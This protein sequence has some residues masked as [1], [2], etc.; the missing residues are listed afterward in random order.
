MRHRIPSFRPVVLWV[1]LT[2]AMLFAA[3]DTEVKLSG[4]VTDASG[5]GLAGVVL[6]LK[7][8]GLSATSDASGNWSISQTT[9]SSEA[10]F[11]KPVTGS[12]IA[13]A[14]T[15][16]I[17]AGTPSNEAISLQNGSVQVSLVQSGLVRVQ[18]YSLAG[19][20]LRTVLQ[21]H[22][23]AGSYTVA[24]GDIPTGMWIVRVQVG[25]KSKNFQLVNAGNGQST[26]RALH[27]ET[28]TRMLAK[29][30]DAS[31]TLLVS[32][33]GFQAGRIG[34][35][36][37]TTGALSDIVIAKVL[38]TLTPDT[39]GT[40]LNVNPIYVLPGTV[41]QVNYFYDASLWQ[42]AWLHVGADSLV[43]AGASYSL[44]LKSASDAVNLVLVRLQTIAFATLADK[45]Y[46]DEDF[47]LN[48]TSTAGLAVSY[49]SKTKNVCTIDDDIV[50]L[51][52]VGTCS[53]EASQAGDESHSAASSV[54]QSFTVT[55]KIL[56][57]E[58]VQ[59]NKIYDGTVYAAVS[60][61]ELGGVV[62]GDDVHLNIGGVLFADAS[63]QTNK[64]ISVLGAKL[65]GTSAG[66]YSLAEITG[67]TASIIPKTVTVV[68]DAKAKVYG[69]QDP[70]FTYT[71]KGLLDGD[72]LTGNLA[73]DTGV[74]A[75]TH[76][77][78]QGSLAAN[79]NYRISFVSENLQITPK[80]LTVTGILNKQTRE[81]D[82]TTYAIIYRY[83]AILNGVVAGDDVGVVVGSASFLDTK[84]GADKPIVVT[85]STLTGKTA[86]N[87]SLAEISGLTGSI[88]PIALSFTNPIPKMQ[89]SDGVVHTFAPSFTVSP[90][91]DVIYTSLTPSVCSYQSTT[92]KDTISFVQVDRSTTYRN[93]FPSGV[94]PPMGPCVIQAQSPTGNYAIATQSFGV[95][96]FSD[97]RDNKI[98][99]AVTIGR[100]VWMAKNLDY[101]TLNEVGSIP[102]GIYGRLYLNSVA[103]NVCPSDWHL[104][105]GAEWDTLYAIADRLTGGRVFAL[106]ARTGWESISSVNSGLNGNG[107]DYF[108]FAALPGGAGFITGDGHGVARTEAGIGSGVYPGDGASWWNTGVASTAPVATSGAFGLNNVNDT[109]FNPPNLLAGVAF[110][111]RCVKDTI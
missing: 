28:S 76:A 29:V 33:Q 87:Y 61:A 2:S 60:D 3:A 71:A 91:V 111:V 24:L 94:R 92:G 55:K 66:C 78:R 106:S 25:D 47:A 100:Q 32:Y 9:T 34:L 48:A 31:D 13:S 85:G 52:G 89:M 6:T 51:V 69:E 109:N 68:A 97:A 46:G 93:D 26:S 80:V 38:P 4:K 63:A 10:A 90:A 81:Y 58:N 70:A 11:V 35:A 5:A 27:G 103:M 49:A 72:T 16:S 108:G 83:S 8:L 84:I 22:L 88:T 23:N 30:D 45:T 107:S 96:E 12:F 79:A 110:S 17:H 105:T 82:G 64:V 99:P 21:E 20:R 56:T 42:P 54:V 43:G 101:D 53:M 62:A 15:T 75:G 86:G 1:A 40:A 95:N 19:Q 50:T 36:S 77:I 57:V 104:P 74:S 59:A 14:P 39:V 67:L 7:D 18:I 73:R 37:L 98:Y 102:N 65:T 44:S 41:F